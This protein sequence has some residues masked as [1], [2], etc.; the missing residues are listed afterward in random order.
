MAIK[1]KDFVVYLDSPA[2]RFTEDASGDSMVPRRGNRKIIYPPRRKAG[3]INFYD[4]GQKKVNNIFQDVPI[5]FTF[6]ITNEQQFLNALNAPLQVALP[7]WKNA[8]KKIAY[9]ES[10][11][12][13]FS[14]RVNNLDVEIIDQQNSNYGEKGLKID[15]D[16]DAF[17]IYGSHFNDAE[18]VF[19]EKNTLGGLFND[20]ISNGYGIKITA[21]PNPDAPAAS[22]FI[23]KARAANIYL[24]QAVFSPAGETLKYSNDTVGAYQ[25]L[26]RYDQDL[27]W[28]QRYNDGVPASLR[29]DADEYVRNSILDNS[30]DFLDFRTNFN[31]PIFK[32]ISWSRSKILGLYQE[33]TQIEQAYQ[34]AANSLIA[35]FGAKAWN[36]TYNDFLIKSY[37]VRNP[38]QGGVIYGNLYWHSAGGFPLAE[39]Y[40]GRITGPT[41]QGTETE[42]Q[43]SSFTVNNDTYLNATEILVENT[44]LAA[45]EQ[46]GEWFFI[47]KKQGGGSL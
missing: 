47:W 3:G 28:W 32:A 43:V 42:N 12:Y 20:F 2:P 17:S 45:V 13:R 8:F 44:L 19:Y 41:G 25:F 10:Q 46:G 18:R 27:L 33:D 21:S 36:Q 14:F 39:D 23:S 40:P 24:N 37:E 7:E 26:E 16:I 1:E 11:K 9:S 5:S 30:R 34:R 4:L 22:L 15:E 6:P 29:Q 38:N 35:D 31:N